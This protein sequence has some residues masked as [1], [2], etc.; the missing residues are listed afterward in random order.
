M[1]FY[2]EDNPIDK[3]TFRFIIF[4][5]LGLII[6]GS[7]LD[8]FD[9]P[10]QYDYGRYTIEERRRDEQREREEWAREAGLQ[11]KYENSKKQTPI[12][13]NNTEDWLDDLENAESGSCIFREYM[14]E[15]DNRDINPGSPEAV[16]IWD[17]YYK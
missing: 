10:V 5:V 8:S 6:L 3:F 11:W 2:F 13:A 17:T 7:I 16:E 12:P 4:P 1:A 9:K 15:L 14:E